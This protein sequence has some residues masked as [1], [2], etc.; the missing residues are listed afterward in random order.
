MR[1]LLPP[2]N[3]L[4]SLRWGRTPFRRTRRGTLSFMTQLVFQHFCAIVRSGILLWDMS[5]VYICSLSARLST[6]SAARGEYSWV[7]PFCTRRVEKPHCPFSAN[8]ITIYPYRFD[9]NE[10]RYK[11]SSFHFLPFISA[12]LFKTILVIIETIYL[13]TISKSISMYIT[14]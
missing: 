1:E 9:K 8:L 12:L 4:W 10:Q 3:R 11:K 5:F 13:Q 14:H 2:H 6:I 7:L